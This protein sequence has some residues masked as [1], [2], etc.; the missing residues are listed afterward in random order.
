[1]DF[2]VGADV[3]NLVSFLKNEN[4]VRCGLFPGSALSYCSIEDGQMGLLLSSDQLSHET[5]SWNSHRDPFLS[6]AKKT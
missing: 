6:W 4:V 5:S 2:A 3:E 1:M